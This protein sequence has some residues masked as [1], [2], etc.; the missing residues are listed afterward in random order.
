VE[1]LGTIKIIVF[2]SKLTFPSRKMSKMRDGIFFYFLSFTNF[3]HFSDENQACEH[4]LNNFFFINLAKFSK[5]LKSSRN[6]NLKIMK[7]FRK[8]LVNLLPKRKC[9]NFMVFKVI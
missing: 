4:E 2:I 9:A 5:H 8:I 3:F 1:V 6:Y 7:T